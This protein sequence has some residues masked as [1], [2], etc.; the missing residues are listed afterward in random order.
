[1]AKGRIDFPATPTITAATQCDPRDAIR[2]P[3]GSKSGLAVVNIL[4]VSISTWTTPVVRI[5][6][7]SDPKFDPNLATSGSNWFSLG[8]TA[9]I[10]NTDKTLTIVLSSMSEWLRWAFEI[11]GGSGGNIRFQVTIHPFDA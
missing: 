7:A 8:A 6:S 1:M 2:I 10:V 11:G 4:S 5:Y 3:S 9:S